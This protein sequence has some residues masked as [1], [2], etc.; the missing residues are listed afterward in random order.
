MLY[1]KGPI[2]CTP[3][4]AGYDEGRIAYINE[5]IQRCIDAGEVLSTIYCVSRKG[6]IFMH[7]AV[8]KHSYN[9]NDDRPA[10][11]DSI[12][13]IA[14]ITKMYTSVA[15][16]QLVE[17][18]VTRLNMPVGEIL[19]QFNT[20]PYNK[21]TL[22]HLLTHT[23]GLH[24]D[25]GCFENKYKSSAWDVISNMYQLHDKADGEFDWI[26]ASLSQGVR[27]E[28]DKEWAYNSFGFVLLGAVIE[29]LTGVFAE[30]YIMDNIVTP[31]RLKDTFF[32]LPK[33]KADRYIIHDSGTE[34]NIDALK[35]SNDS[36]AVQDRGMWAKIPRT[37]GALKSTVYDL[38]RF[39]NM[40]LYDGT[41]DGVR[42]IGRKALEKMKTPSLH[43]IA[44]YCW[45]ANEKNRNFG[46]GFDMRR[47]PEFTFSDTSFYHEGAG[48]CALYID[49]TEELV[50]AWIAPFADDN[51][52]ANA[53]FNTQNVIWSGLM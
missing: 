6:K 12:Q 18:G 14:S 2:E 15:I 34:R 26:A 5:H 33:E 17:N 27:M 4:E 45:G 47:A 30:K 24:P 3:A 43:N 32:E 10:R 22:F 16:M 35:N 23:S 25:A 48:T 29:K 11:P 36:D 21:I 20:P 49:P 50:A 28:P 31:L 8:G 39:G 7:G 42:I 51:W 1:T 13:Y 37:S 41:F 40:L 46:I 53:V 9:E 19:P 52:H 38:A 44:N